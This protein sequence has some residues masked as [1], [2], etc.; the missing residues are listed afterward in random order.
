M[1]PLYNS[2]NRRPPT[3]PWSDFSKNNRGD[4]ASYDG[5][6]YKIDALV[7]VRLRRLP[8]RKHRTREYR[9]RWD[10][11]EPFWDSWLPAQALRH[12][13]ALDDWQR[14]QAM[15][16]EEPDVPPNFPWIKYRAFGPHDPHILKPEFDWTFDSR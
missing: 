7:D 6:Q 1:T 10:G 3:W 4:S 5:R 2:L 8:R 15:R 12:C 11:W 14:Y 16:R 13:A 9:V